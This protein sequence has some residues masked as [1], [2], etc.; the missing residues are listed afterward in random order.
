MVV[1]EHL[2]DPKG[3][4]EVVEGCH[5]PTLPP[6]KFTTQHDLMSTAQKTD[7]TPRGEHRERVEQNV[8]QD[9]LMNGPRRWHVVLFEKKA[10]ELG[11]S[12]I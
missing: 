11:S 10:R 5:P 12:L 1:E 7:G 4:G 9:F 8:V 6:K 3:Q 2:E